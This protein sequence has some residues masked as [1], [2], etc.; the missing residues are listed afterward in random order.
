MNFDTER[1]LTA[2]GEYYALTALVGPFLSVRRSV[3]T[4][5]TVFSAPWAQQTTRGQEIPALAQSTSPI[6]CLLY[7]SDAADEDSSV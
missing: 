1:E 2:S 6:G 7:T 5:F 4:H 3:H